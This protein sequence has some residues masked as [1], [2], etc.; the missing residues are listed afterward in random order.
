MMSASQ[1]ENNSY[2]LRTFNKHHHFWNLYY[3]FIYPAIFFFYASQGRGGG[4][5][6]LG[7][8]SFF[9]GEGKFYLSTQFLNSPKNSPWSSSFK[10]Q[11]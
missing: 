6:S 9:G 1:T 10:M 5:A 7:Y 8:A 11:A 2:S 3:P 4:E